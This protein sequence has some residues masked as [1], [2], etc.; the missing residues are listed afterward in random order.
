MLIGHAG[1]VA[2]CLVVQGQTM[3]LQVV[4][5]A[6]ERKKALGSQ[7]ERGDGSQ[8]RLLATDRRNHVGGETFEKD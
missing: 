2:D 8:K 1:G 7:W 4:V 6:P 3:Q 5:E